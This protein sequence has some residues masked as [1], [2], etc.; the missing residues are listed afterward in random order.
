MQKNNPV[1]IWYFAKL[2]VQPQP[3]NL[4]PYFLK[5]GGHG[6]PLTVISVDV[7][8][9]KAVNGQIWFRTNAEDDFNNH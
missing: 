3:L 1:K 7:L 9:A 6:Q 4:P 8:K 2:V 5:Y